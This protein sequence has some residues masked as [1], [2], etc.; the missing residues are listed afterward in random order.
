MALN[1]QQQLDLEASVDAKSA[2]KNRRKSKN[3]EKWNTLKEE[4]HRLYVL[5]KNTLPTT[6]EIIEK[7]H[8]FKAR[9]VLNH[10]S[11]WQQLSDGFQ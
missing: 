4:I 1:L 11:H 2:R 7:N 6:V 3:G 10:S 5:E 9:F 8:G